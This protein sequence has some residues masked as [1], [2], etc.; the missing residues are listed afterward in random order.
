MLY[1]LR[2]EIF[3]NWDELYVGKAHHN[4]ILVFANMINLMFVDLYLFF[5]FFIG[6]WFFRKSDTIFVFKK[7]AK[8]LLPPIPFRLAK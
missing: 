6:F 5:L 2:L 8:M 1:L 3:L 7:G 4:N